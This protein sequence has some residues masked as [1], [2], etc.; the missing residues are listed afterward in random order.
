M[1]GPESRFFESQGLRLHY[2]DWGN[3]G[4]REHTGKHQPDRLSRKVSVIRDWGNCVVA[5]AV[6]VEPVSNSQ[7][8]C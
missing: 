1:S 4:G 2:A 7:I 6:Q 5:D 3:V 8:P